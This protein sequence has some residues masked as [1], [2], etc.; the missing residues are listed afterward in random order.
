MA[1]WHPT[2][3]SFSF[4]MVHWFHCLQC[5]STCVVWQ[6]NPE[7]GERACNDCNV[8]VF[9]LYL[10]SVYMI[11][12]WLIGLLFNSSAGLQF[13]ISHFLVRD[14]DWLV[15]LFFSLISFTSPTDQLFNRRCWTSRAPTVWS[16][17]STWLA[18]STSPSPVSPLSLRFAARLL[19]RDP[20]P[21]SSQGS[22]KLSIWQRL[23]PSLRTKS[24]LVFQG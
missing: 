19:L 1:S 17:H 13:F 20:P 4:L 24:R 5:D 14:C 3:P 10:Y 2:S 22:W 11:I 16:C 12:W 23:I 9:S 18:T 15:G 8:F 7:G 6:W 21:C